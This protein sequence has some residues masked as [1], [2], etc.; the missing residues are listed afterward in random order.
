MNIGLTLERQCVKQRFT[1]T[2]FPDCRRERQSGCDA[3]DSA[4]Y[5]LGPVSST[6]SRARNTARSLASHTCFT[7]S[8]DIAEFPSSQQ[9]V[10]EYYLR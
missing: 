7:L 5:A 4:S 8:W 6:C 10:T 3:Q 9:P 2:G 1:Y